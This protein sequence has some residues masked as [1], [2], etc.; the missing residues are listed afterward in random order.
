MR[1]HVYPVCVCCFYCWPF[2]CSLVAVEED[3]SVMKRSALR[4]VIQSWLSW[5]LGNLFAT[6]SCLHMFFLNKYGTV[7]SVDLL[8]FDQE[9][10]ARLE[11]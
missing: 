6:S 2:P 10:K 9:R 5:S 3:E 11:C 4:C 8:V 1:A 7:K